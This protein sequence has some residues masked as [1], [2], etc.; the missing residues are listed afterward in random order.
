ML[1]KPKWPTYFLEIA[2]Q[3]STRTT[4]LSP[5]KGAVIVINKR[6]IAT[7]YN[8]APS[9]TKDCKYDTGMC[10][11]RSL[12]FGSGEG[13]DKCKA[14]HAEI[15]AILQAARQ[16]ISIE[17]AEMYC[18]H[19]PCSECAKLIVNSG[20]VKVTYLEDYPNDSE[21]LFHEAQIKIKRW[22]P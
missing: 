21:E 2:K 10:Y 18:T 1:E 6:I 11:K 3:V 22:N 19:K 20:I 7:G 13:H 4:C 17:G 9:N 15:N 12:G 8:G 14:I 5:G 16:G